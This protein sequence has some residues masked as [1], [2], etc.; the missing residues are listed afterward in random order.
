MATDDPVERVQW[1]IGKKIVAIVAEKQR[2]KKGNLKKYVTQ[3]RLVKRGQC[4]IVA[5]LGALFFQLA[6]IKLNSNI[7][8]IC[9]RAAPD[10]ISTILFIL[11]GDF[12]FGLAPI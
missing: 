1:P 6:A 3:W 5:T 11:S 12:S 8:T 9:C 10:V 7:E 2:T 4:I